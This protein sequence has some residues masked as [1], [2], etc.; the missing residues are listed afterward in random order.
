MRQGGV[1]SAY[2][3]AIYVDDLIRLIH[4]SHYGCHIGVFNVNIFLYA[5]DIL[6][7]APSVDALQK[8]FLLCESYLV[9]M[10]MALNANK[11]VCL[12]IGP[13]YKDE[14]NPLITLSGESLCWVNS[15]HL[16]RCLCI[17]RQEFQNFV[18][19]QQDVLL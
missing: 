19:E 1:L 12:R 15:C 6:L 7:V 2:F 13:R 8:M 5:D 16:F 14:C 18:G 11:S 17:G 4:S 10:D 3:F 9:D